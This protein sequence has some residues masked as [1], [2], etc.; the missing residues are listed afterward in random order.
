[1]TT[2]WI[3][4]FVAQASLV[5]LLG[6]VVL[7]LL[8]RITPLIEESQELL[9]TAS[10]RLTI[11]GLPPG[12]T[13][14]RFEAD[15]IGGGNVTDEDLREEQS[16][17]LFL[18]DGCAACERFVADLESGGVPDVHA[19]LVVVSN[20]REAAER[21]ARSKRV[22]IVVDD[23]RSVARAF[24]SV[25]SPQAFVVDEQGMALTSGTPNTWDEMRQLVD[26]ARGG[27]RRS[28]ATAA[29]VASNNMTDEIQPIDQPNDDE[30]AAEPHSSRGQFLKRLGITLA[31]GVGV[32]AAL[33]S[34]AR[35][36]SGQCCIDCG[37]CGSCGGTNCF[38]FCDCSGIGKS[39]CWTASQ[40][41]LSSGCVG[42]PC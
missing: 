27:G 38:C 25:V 10:R 21:L 18:D 23:E 16:V 17:V 28:N 33:A 31:A 7:G 20:V 32:A 41:C 37:T 35:A 15:E 8:R 12:A 5:V 13:V 26:H 36:G 19:R 4:A 24:E 39:Y 2:P 29:S 40:G 14:P 6:L 34:S 22:T 11:G 1:M 3:V 30:R 42:C 9:T